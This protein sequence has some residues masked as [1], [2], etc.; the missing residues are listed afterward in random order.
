MLKSW[1]RNLWDF[2]W[3][4]NETLQVWLRWRYYWHEALILDYPVSPI[5][6]TGNL[7]SWETLFCD[8]RETSSLVPQWKS[9]ELLCC[10]LWMCR[11]MGQRMWKSLEISRNRKSNLS[12]VSRKEHGSDSALGQRRGW[13][14][15]AYSSAP[16]TWLPWTG[17]NVS[18]SPLVTPILII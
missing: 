5:K 18:S 8:Q 3:D 9:Q 13:W 14:D 16:I 4:G 10:G 6:S 1:S 7:D 12:R 2:N 15:V 11:V 17:S